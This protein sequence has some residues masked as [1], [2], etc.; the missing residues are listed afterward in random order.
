MYTKPTKCVVKAAATSPTF[1]KLLTIL[2]SHQHTAPRGCP[3]WSKSYD[4]SRL[5][6][7]FSRTLTPHLHIVLPA[8]A[9]GRSSSTPSSQPKAVAFPKPAPNSTFTPPHIYPLCVLR[10]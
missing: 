7:I 9:P 6:T 3:H 8:P 10:N 4:A 1:P 5:S 2:S